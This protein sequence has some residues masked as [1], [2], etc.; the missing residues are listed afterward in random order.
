MGQACPGGVA[1]DM[2]TPRPRF[3]TDNGGAACPAA[4]YQTPLVAIADLP[5]V[6]AALEGALAA[7]VPQGA[8]PTTP[9][10]QGALAHLRMRAMANPDRKPVLVLATDGLPTTCFPNSVDTAVAALAAAQMAAPA[11]STYVIGVFGPAQLAR[12]R[13]ALERMATAGGSGMP[14]VLTTGGD[15]SQRFLEAINQIRG[16]ALGCEFAIPRPTQ[17]SLDFDRVNVRFN[18][19]A[20]GE[21]LRYVE[22]ADRCDPARG[23]WYY[24]IN[25][26]TGT[27]AR[28]LLCEATCNKIKVTAGVSVDLRFGCK[29]IV[30]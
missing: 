9:A 3:C 2:C 4:R 24:D 14:F 17:G 6:Q 15:L 19:A 18:S 21:D 29:T 16:S 11:I 23:G 8:T 22:S 7:I 26:R 28:V 13:P 1:G 25:P 27:P 30:E 10:V 20:G 12:S 5:G